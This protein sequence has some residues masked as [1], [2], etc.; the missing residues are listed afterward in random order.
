MPLDRIWW[1]GDGGGDGDGDGGG[2]GDDE[3]RGERRWAGMWAMASGMATVAAAV[4]STNPAASDLPHISR[5]ASNG[6]EEDGRFWLG[7]DP[8]LWLR[9]TPRRKPCSASGASNGDALGCQQ[10][11]QRDDETG[12]FDEISWVSRQVAGIP[13]DVPLANADAI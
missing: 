7:L 2:V 3:D 9:G 8:V 11:H 1:D 12:E 4:E 10:Q 13:T 6:G 5:L